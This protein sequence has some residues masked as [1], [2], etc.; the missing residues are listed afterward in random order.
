M[1]VEGSPEDQMEFQDAAPPS[2][3]R[4][5]I[6]PG[7]M[8]KRQAG[9]LPGHEL[10]VYKEVGRNPT[11][12]SPGCGGSSNRAG[13]PCRLR[14]VT[15]I[16]QKC[17]VS[18]GALQRTSTLP[19]SRIPTMSYYHFVG[20]GCQLLY[21]STYALYLFFSRMGS[22]KTLKLMLILSQGRM[23]FHWLLDISRERGSAGSKSF[24]ASPRRVG[25]MRN[26]R[27]CD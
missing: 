20:R 24:R 22:G 25:W 13:A 26:A 8:T 4:P 11:P 1:Y 5:R 15:R 16:H 12:H 9:F 2:P 23:D 27:P 6:C 14:N 7:L 18:P 10:H 17:T 3:V 21:L 19:A